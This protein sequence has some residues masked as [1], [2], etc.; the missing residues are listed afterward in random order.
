MLLKRVASALLIPALAACSSLQPAATGPQ[1]I[2]AAWSV[3]STPSIEAVAFGED[4]AVAVT[5]VTRDPLVDGDVHVSGGSITRGTNALTPA[6]AAVDSLDVSEERG[7]VVFSAKRDR[8]FDIGLVSTDGSKVNWVPEEALDEVAVQWAPRGN[9]VSYVVRAQAGDLVRTV[10]IPTAYQLSVDF[11]WGRVSSLAWEKP[12]ERFAVVVD[13]IDASPH[14]EVMKYDGRSR[15]VAIPPAKRL[16]I[17]I[18]PLAGALLL[19]PSNLKYGEQ[20]P[21]AIWITEGDRNRWNDARAQL[22]DSR[23]AILLTSVAPDATLREALGEAKWIDPSRR[24]VVD[25]RASAGT[26]DAAAG[27]VIIRANSSVPRD[28]WVRHGNVV[29]TSGSVESFAAGFIADQVKGTST[30]NGHR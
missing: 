10:H 12:A 13:S 4:G 3:P 30:T 17:S 6:F 28:R 7:E 1:A 29:E 21:L 23:V 9:K 22:L 2:P 26:V 8:S 11:P 15:S 25:A 14:V 24:Y 5:G 27:E 18:E 20:L 16:D 19:R